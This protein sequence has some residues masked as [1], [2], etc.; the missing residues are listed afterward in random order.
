M[1]PHKTKTKIICLHHNKKTLSPTEGP[2]ANCNHYTLNYLNEVAPIHVR[3]QSTASQ[4]VMPSPHR[5][6]P[7][8]VS[9]LH[10]TRRKAS[11]AI[12]TK[13]GIA[14]LCMD[15]GYI[16]IW[17][18]DQHEEKRALNDGH[19]RTITSVTFSEKSN[20]LVSGDDA[21]KISHD[22]AYLPSNKGYTS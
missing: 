4:T 6:V 16:C 18:I 7:T 11:I 10:R 20:H 5:M 2:I 21:A 15:D 12:H 13:K 19:T 22:D 1:H 14:A 17:N 3:G 8:R 9:I